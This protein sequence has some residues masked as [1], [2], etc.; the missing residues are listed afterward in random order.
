MCISRGLP[1]KEAA[2]AVSRRLQMLLCK[3]QGE[4]SVCRNARGLE[5][6]QT[7]AYGLGQMGSSLFDAVQGMMFGRARP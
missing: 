7:L 3:P 4:N 5:K 1:D 2:N 6:D